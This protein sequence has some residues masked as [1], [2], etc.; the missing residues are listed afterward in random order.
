[1]NKPIFIIGLLVAI[2]ANFLLP[3]LPRC[4]SDTVALPEPRLKGSVSLEEAIYRRRSVRTFRDEPLDLA[5]VSQILWAAGGKTIDGITGPT[6]SYP[7]AGGIYPLA[8]YLAAGKVT[9][10]APGVY[11]YDWS[12]HSLALVRAGDVRASLSL[13]AGGQTAVASA[14]ASIVIVGDPGK[15]SARYGGRGVER[16]LAMDSG[17]AGENIHL[18]V[19]ALGLGT[20][21]VGAFKDEAVLEALGIGGVTPLYIMPVGK[22][23]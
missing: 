1:M 3:N 23:D 16:Y 17:H 6:R 12:K 11:R 19:Q 18:Q 13:A 15:I 5:A 9:G 14:P 8:I 7:S 2:L 4:Q 10:L 20:V 22:P 21:A